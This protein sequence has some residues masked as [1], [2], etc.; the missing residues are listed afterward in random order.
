MLNT[1]R[2]TARTE[3]NMSSFAFSNNGFTS[4]DDYNLAAIVIALRISPRETVDECLDAIWTELF[5]SDRRETH[6]ILQDRDTLKTLPYPDTFAPV[7]EDLSH[8][9]KVRLF[10][11]A[12]DNCH[13]EPD[14]FVRCM[15][16]FLTSSEEFLDAFEYWREDYWLRL[17]R[18]SR[19]SSTAH[20][21]FE[22]TPITI[23]SDTFNEQTSI[24]NSMIPG[25]DRLQQRKF[26]SLF[27]SYPADDFEGVSWLEIVLFGMHYLQNSSSAEHQA[28]AE[29]VL[30][31]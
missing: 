11:V 17:F 13:T 1:G 18:M 28:L 6:A 14:Q 25:T 8:D 10:D 15:R 4:L 23:D 26:A 7:A 27:E 20:E 22:K 29:R 2:F 3:E 24:A 31:Q 12:F 5:R 16:S 9:E 30:K 19:M 21:L